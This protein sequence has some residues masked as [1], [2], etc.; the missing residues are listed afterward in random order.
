MLY[1]LS[2]TPAGGLRLYR[3]APGLASDEDGTI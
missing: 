2:Y 1:Q 3:G